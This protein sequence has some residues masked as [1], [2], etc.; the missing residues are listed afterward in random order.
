[1]TKQ[2]IIREG[3]ANTQMG[4]APEASSYAVLP[5]KE[6]YQYTDNIIEFLHSQG[7]VIKVDRELP[8]EFAISDFGGGLGM[9][10]IPLFDKNGIEE[11]GYVAVEP[12]VKD[13]PT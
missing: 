11:A 2:D 3:I 5:T 4:W 8:D 12:L 13:L 6:A 1:M 9:E 10:S 7:V